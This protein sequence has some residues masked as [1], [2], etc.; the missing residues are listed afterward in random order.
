V[1]LLQ[2]MQPRPRL[3][4][5]AQRDRVPPPVRRPGRADLPERPDLRRPVAV[6]AEGAGG[7]VP[8]LIVRAMQSWWAAL[9]LIGCG[10]QP[11]CG[12]LG[13]ACCMTDACAAGANCTNHLC[14][15]ACGRLAQPCCVGSACSEGA[16]VQ[17]TCTKDV[18]GAD[19]QPCCA[20]ATPCNASLVCA[21]GLCV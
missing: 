13:Q 4:L 17:G 7:R 16:C 21:N 11:P 1:P 6:G 9:L 2:R 20:T 15:P 14:Q 5:R 3:P 12:A 19:G 8:G 18:C 10:G